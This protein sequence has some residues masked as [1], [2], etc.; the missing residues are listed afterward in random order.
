[1]PID[2]EAT[3]SLRFKDGSIGTIHY[4]ASGHRSLS[5]ERVEVFCSGRV[6]QLDNFRSLA[7][8]GWPGFKGMRLGRQDKG[9]EA[10]IRSVVEAIRTGRPSPIPWEEI[11]DVTNATFEADR[12][13]R[14]RA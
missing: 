4:L 7:A 2:D 12:Q 10:E 3:I 9:H 11:V 1:M 6:L 13:I 5:K 14:M 8:Y